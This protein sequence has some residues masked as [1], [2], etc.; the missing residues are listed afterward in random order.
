MTEIEREELLSAYLDDELSVDERTRV[1][2]WLAESAE[3]RQLRD[4]LLTLRAGL[5]TLPQHKLDRDLA[6][7]VLRRAEQAV[8]R[9][10]TGD[11][12][13]STIV[14]KSANWWERRSNLR[15]LIWPA[16]AVAAALVILVYDANQRPDELHVAQ[17]PP[18]ATELDSQ[19][20]GE[21]GSGASVGAA[22]ESP[23][24]AFSRDH[25]GNHPASGEP[26]AN[27]AK[28][29]VPAPESS[30]PREPASRPSADL[31][32]HSEKMG[33][34]PTVR[35][36]A[37]SMQDASPSKTVPLQKKATPLFSESN[38]VVKADTQSPIVC[39]VSAEYFNGKRFEKLLDANDIAWEKLTTPRGSEQVSVESEST[40]RN[41][42]AA[43]RMSTAPLQSL[44]LLR[45]TSSQVDD[46]LSQVP[47]PANLGPGQ[48][49]ILPRVAS[50]RLESAAK[51]QAGVQILLVAPQQET[52]GRQ[53]R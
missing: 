44:Y 30:V 6:T 46:I 40:N 50:P 3:L 29:A 9:S 35:G 52:P 4:D 5:Q 13:D 42:K 36:Q 26:V 53:S 14:P 39:S 17:A 33:G 48:Q 7:S 2:G 38:G 49:I 12:S 16:L 20:G 32:Q 8:L 23:P 18:E 51:I 43:D 47:R 1:E 10:K 25:L 22:S 31:F 15:R 21:D 28:G 27:Y 19:N 41:G 34:H 45:A 24:N 11:F 37:R